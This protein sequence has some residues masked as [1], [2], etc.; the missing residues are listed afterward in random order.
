MGDFYK[1]GTTLTGT[2]AQKVYKHP[3]EIRQQEQISSFDLAVLG[4][5]LVGGFLLGNRIMSYTYR[6]SKGLVNSVRKM[7]DHK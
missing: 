6:L 3:K 5:T 7:Y 1:A 4:A 2:I